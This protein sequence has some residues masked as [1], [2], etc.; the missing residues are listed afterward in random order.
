M[1]KRNARI[2]I[3]V[4]AL[5][6]FASWKVVRGGSEEFSAP[7]VDAGLRRVGA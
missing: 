2:V 3:V 4:L 6:A 5:V 1:T 7:N